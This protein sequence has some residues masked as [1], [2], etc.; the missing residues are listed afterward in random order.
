MDVGGHVM[1]EVNAWG[2]YCKQNVYWKHELSGKAR[3]FDDV[4]CVGMVCNVVASR[5]VLLDIALFVYILNR[6]GL[7][8][9]IV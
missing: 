9:L 3:P 8:K 1:V 5:N 6:R 7:F 4:N 2:S